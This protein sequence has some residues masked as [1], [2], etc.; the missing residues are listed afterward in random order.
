MEVPEILI[1]VLAEPV[2][3]AAAVT[4]LVL[5]ILEEVAGTV[6]QLELTGGKVQ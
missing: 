2:A 3:A 1:Q 5:P 4:S 6:E